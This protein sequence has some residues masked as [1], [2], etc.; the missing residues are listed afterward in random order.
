MTLIRKLLNKVQ[1]TV[2]ITNNTVLNDTILDNIILDNY[3][4]VKTAITL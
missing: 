1:Y 4:H 3:L 2:Y